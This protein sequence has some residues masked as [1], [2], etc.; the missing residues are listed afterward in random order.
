VSNWRHTV[1]GENLD[2]LTGFPFKSEQYTEDDNDIG[3]LRGDNIGQ[4][5]VR[6]EDAKRWPRTASAGLDKYR[7]QTGD[8]VVAMDRTW[9]KAGLKCAIITQKD[10]PSLL[11]QRVARLRG[12]NSLSTRLLSQLV[13]THR[14]E[15]YVKAVQTETA[16]HTSA[17]T[18]C[19]SSPYSCRQFAS[20][21]GLRMF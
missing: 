19:A 7:L 8:I 21:S 6:W 16:L 20:R 3:L 1:V 5:S 12:G 18:S 2:L 10:V 13:R 15:Q 4:G 17:V 14:F 11:V 9:V